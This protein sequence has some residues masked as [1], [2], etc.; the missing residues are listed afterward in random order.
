MPLPPHFSPAVAEYIRNTT[1]PSLLSSSASPSPLLSR[2]IPT[3]TGSSSRFELGDPVNRLC[4]RLRLIDEEDEHKPEHEQQDELAGSS[5]ILGCPQAIAATTDARPG[6]RRR[7]FTT[8][9]EMRTNHLKARLDARRV[10]TPAS[11]SQPA[12][13]RYQYRAVRPALQLAD[14][15]RSVDIRRSSSH[16]VVNGLQ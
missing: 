2:S 9:R 11:S 7:V 15:P 6:T 1:S 8:Y 16:Q 4:F 3:T 13:R 14:V 5:H 10:R 12:C